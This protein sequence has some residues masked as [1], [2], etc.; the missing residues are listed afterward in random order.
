MLVHAEAPHELSG[1]CSSGEDER[2]VQNLQMCLLS[3][4][5]KPD[6]L[7]ERIVASVSDLTDQCVRL[8]TNIDHNNALYFIS[9][10][11]FVSHIT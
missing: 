11:A 5:Y 8:E 10:I 9:L 3:F 7:S 4:N 6:V 1:K 2:R